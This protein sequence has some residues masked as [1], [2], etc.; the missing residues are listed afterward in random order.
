MPGAVGLLLATTAET[1][2]CQG[3]AGVSVAIPRLRLTRQRPWRCRG[4]GGGRSVGVV[5]GGGG[6]LDAVVGSG[7]VVSGGGGDVVVVGSGVLALDGK[8]RRELWPLL[9]TR[10]VVRTP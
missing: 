8:L 3:A 2:P 9:S 4:L 1:A 5:V 10:A 6:G 7:V